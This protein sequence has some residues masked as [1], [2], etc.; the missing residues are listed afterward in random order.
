MNAVSTAMTNF[1]SVSV[2]ALAN[3]LSGD[4][5]AVT[6]SVNSIVT[7]MTNG[8]Q[9]K[10]YKFSIEGRKLMEKL[11]SG[12]DGKSDEAKKTLN[13]IVE[14]MGKILSKLQN[15]SF[16][17]GVDTVQGFIDGMMSKY[18]DAIA[19]ANKIAK[20]VKDEVN[21]TLD[22]NS[23]AKTM[24]PSGEAV[25]EGLAL[26][27]LRA[28]STVTDASEKL[29]TDTSTTLGA[30]LADAVESFDDSE[31][32]PVITPVLNL[33]DVNSGFASINDLMSAYNIGYAG[34]S[35]PSVYRQA[36]TN[37]VIDAIATL[38]TALANAGGD[39]YNID[40][41]TYDDGS[42]VSSAVQQLIY[43]ANIARR[44]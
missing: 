4:M 14:D 40:G 13:D 27:M 30:I 3:S 28:S 35:V 33:D 39:T 21:A 24:I 6:N 31:L 10:R 2:E 25:C 22:I 23:P 34:N 36:S 37:D 11:I 44:I 17:S 1:S 43:A 42:N 9:Y 15:G 18:V 19:A 20:V 16:N 5:T 7:A 8:F 38:G 41:I 29:A 32:S 26:G 12:I